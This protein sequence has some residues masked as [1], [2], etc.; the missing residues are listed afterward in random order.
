[1]M[2]FALNGAEFVIGS[3]R[4]PQEG[5]CQRD[6]AAFSGHGLSRR[7]PAQSGYHDG[8]LR[9]ACRHARLSRGGQLRPR[10]E[11]QRQR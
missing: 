9:R 1:M 7:S 10:A 2:L 3:A 11:G 5:A 4:A 6:E 8:R